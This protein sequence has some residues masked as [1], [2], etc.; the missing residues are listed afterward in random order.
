MGEQSSRVSAHLEYLAQGERDIKVHEIH[1]GEI[2][3]TR[4]HQIVGPEPALVPE[5]QQRQEDDRVQQEVRQISEYQ[6]FR[7]YIDIK[8]LEHNHNFQWKYKTQPDEAE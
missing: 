5:L 8:D 2:Q 4:G 1:T 6:G 7:P 3:V